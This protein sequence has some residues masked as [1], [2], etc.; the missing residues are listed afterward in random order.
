MEEALGPYKS[1]SYKGLARFMN[2]EGGYILSP[3]KIRQKFSVK[4]FNELVGTRDEDG[5]DD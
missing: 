5:A 3:E 1:Y 2:R 4:Y